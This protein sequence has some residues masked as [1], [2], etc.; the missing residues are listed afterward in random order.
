MPI[1]SESTATG[2]GRDNNGE[3]GENTKGSAPTDDSSVS[4]SS[5]T[6][7][8]HTD[9][10]ETMMSTNS[11]VDIHSKDPP[12]ENSAALGSGTVVNNGASIKEPDSSNVARVSADTQNNVSLAD[13][14][15]AYHNVAAS[16]GVNRDNSTPIPR[17][18]QSSSSTGGS[19]SPHL[20]E[21]LNS[22]AG[23]L[24][25]QLR[26]DTSNFM[27][28]LVESLENRSAY[29]PGEGEEEK[30]ERMRFNETQRM[31][32]E[33]TSDSDLMQQVMRAASN[34]EMA[35]ELARQADTA[36][37]NIEALPG[38]FRALYQ[39]HRNIQ[40]PLWQAITNGGPRGGTSTSRYG[41]TTPPK[42]TEP[43][44]VE[45]L[46]NPWAAPTRPVGPPAF[47]PSALGSLFPGTIVGKGKSPLGGLGA[48]LRPA[49]NASRN[50]MQSMSVSQPSAGLMSTV[51]PHVGSP[52]VVPGASSTIASDVTAAGSAAKEEV[53]GQPS[54]KPDVTK[55]NADRY[56]LELKELADMGINDLDRCLTALEAADGDLFQ[57]LGLLQS[58]DELDRQES[59]K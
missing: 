37:R 54:G 40:Q 53:T 47:S 34:P 20:E 16:S 23:N 14:S 56:A 49:S 28:D 50:R 51:Q 9:G 39:M 43:L 36:W 29:N 59:E 35:K 12:V 2:A 55:T 38:G 41:H 30:E 27:E 42:P 11:S 26:P 15:P 8:K 33:L 13:I 1:T 22:V 19:M 18:R 24:M 25:K 44:N 46:P 5:I 21:M 58:L 4:K 17:S 31:L 3:S 10:C 7:S 6:V 45:P 48:L 57:A 52:A 32:R